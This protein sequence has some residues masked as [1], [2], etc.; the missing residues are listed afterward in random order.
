M[1]KIRLA[2]EEEVQEIAAESNLTPF[3]RVLVLGKMK[4]VWKVCNEL[5]PVFFGDAP[6]PLMYKFL[7]GLENIMKG[8]GVTEYFYNV[9]AD[10]TNYHAVL[11]KLGAER[12]SKQPD[13]RYKINL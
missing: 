4:A 10:D 12:Q 6:K 7:W 9:P 2:T 5:D 8:S 13:F 1:D 11:E 3:S